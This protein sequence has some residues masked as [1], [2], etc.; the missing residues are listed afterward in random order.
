MDSNSIT[1][2][3]AI[4]ISAGGIILGIIN[5]KFVRSKCC[6]KVLEASIDVGNTTPPNSSSKINPN[7]LI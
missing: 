1:G 6:G 7:P 5:H 4:G 3:I 2:Y